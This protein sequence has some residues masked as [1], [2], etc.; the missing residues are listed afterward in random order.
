M[1]AAQSVA[2]GLKLV[3]GNAR[4]GMLDIQPNA[5]TEEHFEI[6]CIS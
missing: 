6:A 1:W 4:F 3:C 5:I 2:S